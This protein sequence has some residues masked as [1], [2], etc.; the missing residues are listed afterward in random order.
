MKFLKSTVRPAFDEVVE[1]F[2]KNGMDAVVK[3]DEAA[4][5][6]WIEVVHGEEADFFYSVHL[7]G[8]TL[9]SFTTADDTM[10]KDDTNKY[11]RAEVYLKEGGQD[12]G[13][14]GW[15]KEQLINNVL[16][17][18]EKHMHFLHVIR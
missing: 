6:V 2:A 17:Q 10:G 4:G 18:Y 7:K 16:D 11:Y 14:M 15:T 8:H 9:P 12:Y 3:E 1:A 13:V 5:K